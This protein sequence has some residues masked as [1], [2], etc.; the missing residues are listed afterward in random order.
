MCLLAAKWNVSIQI[1]LLRIDGWFWID[2]GDHSSPKADKTID[3]EL[4]KSKENSKKSYSIYT[5]RR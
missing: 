3:K 5:T 4:E 2:L 1:V